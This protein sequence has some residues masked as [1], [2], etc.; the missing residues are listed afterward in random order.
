MRLN[1]ILSEAKDL[2]RLVTFWMNQ[3]E[4]WRFYMFSEFHFS[5]K[6]CWFYLSCQEGGR[7]D[8]AWLFL[9]FVF[10]QTGRSYGTKISISDL[11]PWACRMVYA[12]VWTVIWEIY[13]IDMIRVPQNNLGTQIRCFC[14]AEALEKH[15]FFC[16]VGLFCLVEEG[17]TPC[18]PLSRGG[19]FQTYLFDVVHFC[20]YLWFLLLTLI[21]RLPDY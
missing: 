1:V 4:F 11:S 18:P 21:I 9:V 12:F 13:L 7:S 17:H 3:Y 2:C 20:F 10:L 16:P 14:H 8:G 6:F 5:Y 15:P 19:I